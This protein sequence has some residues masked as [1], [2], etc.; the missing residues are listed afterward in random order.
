VLLIV[1]AVPDFTMTA[2]PPSNSV[3]QGSGAAYTATVSSLN[4]FTGNV[5]LS[6]SG[7]PAGAGYSFNPA[8]IAGS[9]TS[10]LTIT[11]SSSTP[12][13]TYSLTI[14]GTSGSLVHSAVVT[15]AVTAPSDFALT[16]APPSNTVAQGSGTSYT[17]TVSSL[18]GF[19]GNVDLSLSGLPAGAAYSFNPTSIT[20]SGTSALTITTSS[21]TPMG[22]YSLTITGTSGNLVHSAVV[23]LVVAAAGDFALSA[24][25][26][27]QS[28]TRGAATSY[29]VTVAPVGGFNN[30]VVLS[31]SGLPYASYASFSPASVTG[32]GSSVLTVDTSRSTKAGTYTL[33]IK[34]TSGS[35]SRTTVVTLVVHQ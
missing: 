19:T 8:S 11:T 28:V 34:G 22:T 6:I 31:V 30:A 14:T 3:I 32:P 10:A 33:T 24:T 35:L 29:T 2:T 21:S 1:N 13:G 5:D 27:I 9:G 12:T 25:P 4:G 7:V 23:T 17:A 16:A 15:L 26:S 20:G 18:N